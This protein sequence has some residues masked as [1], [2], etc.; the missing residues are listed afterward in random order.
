MVTGAMRLPPPR[1]KNK[2]HS[3]GNPTATGVSCSPRL[4][5][6]HGRSAQAGLPHAALYLILSPTLFT[7]MPK[8]ILII[9]IL[10]CLAGVFAA[11]D[12]ISGL[13]RSHL[14][15]NFAVFSLPVGIG[16]L[17]GREKSRR[18]A[19][20]WII[21]GYIACGL[22]IVLS[23]LN[24]GN[25]QATFFDKSL[26]GPPALLV[27]YPMAVAAA[28]ILYIINRLLFSVRSNEH[29]GRSEHTVAEMTP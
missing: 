11:W 1:H 13:T 29:F 15:L 19:R 4:G 3:L 7:H 28:G 8:R 16:L 18:W 20:F 5:K 17:R 24:P 9:G 14:N 27:I 2:S 10:F 23:A 26:S 22:L 12:I 25:A 6:P 21:L